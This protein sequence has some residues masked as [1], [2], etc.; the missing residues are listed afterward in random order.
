M[1]WKT[2]VLTLTPLILLATACSPQPP[3][4]TV[5][6]IPCEKFSAEAGDQ[7]RITRNVSVKEGGH[8]VVRLCTNP[9]TGFAWEDADVS[10]PTVL[11][12]RSRE[13]IPPGVTM[14]GSA[15]L[16]QWTFEAIGDGVC[17]VALSYSRPWEGGEKGIWLFELEVTVA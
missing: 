9:S 12:E 3:R 4:D 5:V 11:V 13:F 14:P 8:V 1:G 7:V 16:E 6:E 15:G 2:R 17:T 10:T